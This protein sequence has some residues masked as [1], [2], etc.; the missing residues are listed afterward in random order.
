MSPD[1]DLPVSAVA[2]GS[3]SLSS[4]PSSRPLARRLLRRTIDLLVV[5]F[6]VVVGLSTGSQLVEW[7]RTDASQISPDVS[8]LVSIDLDWNRTPIMLRFGEAS[9][10]LERIPFHGKRGQLEEELV[11]IG[12]S[13]VTTSE[14]GSAP[15]EVAELDW[16]TDLQ[17]AA[18]VFWD[19]TR[20]NVYRRDEPL[21]SFVATRFVDSSA[22]VPAQDG[23]AP[24]QR[25]VGWGLAFP[26]GADDWTIYVFHP[27]SA[28]SPQAEN[29]PVIALPEGASNVTNLSGSDGCQWRVIQGRGELASWVQHFDRQF[30]TGQTVARVIHTQTASLKYRRDRILTDVHIRREPDGRLTG[31][32]WSAKER[33]TR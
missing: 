20:G 14:I 8:D 24:V 13:I 33:E 1:D 29:R 9:T 25:I 18:P 11:R 28:K 22:K 15:P 4:V 30:G 23:E 17:A 16:L 32:L 2:S 3:R 5:A 26:S 12:Q 31:V 19:S 6:L 27:D 10:S 7:W 21:P